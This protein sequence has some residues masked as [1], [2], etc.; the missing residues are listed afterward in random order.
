MKEMRKAFLCLTLAAVFALLAAFP[1]MFP[2]GGNTVYADGNGF[3]I[4]DGV[5]YSYTGSASK[6]VIPGSVTS[7][8]SWAFYCCSDMK[9]VTIPASVKSIGDYAFY[10][11]GG[12][13]GVTLPNSVA[14]LGDH[15]FSNCTGL[16]SVTISKSVKT[17]GEE[18]F[19]SCTSLENVTVD[20]GNT[21]FSSA[22][23]ILYNKDK[24]R[25]LFCPVA[26]SG[27]LTL[28]STLTEIGDYAFAYCDRLTG[29]TL[30][31]S[32]KKIGAWAF[33]FC[34]GLTSLTIPDSVTAI[35][36]HAFDGCGS[37]QTVT[38]SGSA[39]AIGEYAFSGCRSLKSIT[40]PATLK[41]LGEGAFWG[42]GSLTA[43]NIPKSVTGIGSMAFYGM[44]KL[45][46]ISVDSANANYSSEAGVL[47]N[48]NK[49]L[50][51]AC[52]SGKT[53]TVTLPSSVTRVEGAAFSGCGMITAINLPSSLTAIGKRA[54]ESCTGLTVMTVPDSI[55][56]IGE[57]AF[58]GC[59]ALQEVRYPGTAQ[60]WKKLLT[61]ASGVQLDAGLTS[62]V[63]MQYNYTPAPA[64]KITSQPTG[65]TV[66]KGSSFTI[67]VKA[68]GSGLKYQWYFKKKGAS[69]W[70]IWNGRTHASETVTPNDTW[71]GIQLYCLIKDDSDHS[72]K[73][74]A[75]TV[76]LSNLAITAQPQSKT[77]V[78]G[79]SVTL[80][81][82]ATG[83]GLK[84]QWYFKKK[85]A[86]AWSVWNGRTHA[87]ETVTPNDTWDGIQLY[88]LIKDSLG[89]SLKSGT[90][91]VTFGTSAI[92]VTQQPK[93]QSIVVG[94]SLTLSVK[95]TGSD[96]KYQWYFRKKGQTS[97]SVWNNRTHAS[98]TVSPNNLWDGIQLYCK[99]TDGS[100]KSVQSSTVTVSV[101]SITS[102]P[103]NVTVAA[104]SNATFA[105]KATGSGL[106]YQWQY[107]KKGASSWSDWGSRTAASTT[108]TANATWNAMQVRCKVTDG[109]GN[110]LYS[111]AATVTIK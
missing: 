13:T 10:Y 98:E 51:I 101:L 61:D 103:A 88:C 100:G 9:E 74:E 35:G 20:S 47:Y 69:A 63:K 41:T 75:A 99:I 107:K 7:I 86:S 56:K 49:T 68:T 66:I 29:V 23:G 36:A 30:P 37:L 21:V 95:A 93:N 15:V 39:A 38:M 106:Q 4:R 60:Q 12:L 26:K 5:L 14:T 105:V 19:E 31:A 3:D 11:C 45:S 54:F 44:T 102:Q 42:C 1:P 89:A 46:A 110:Y 79:S 91:S 111:S 48:K 33:E 17:I 77:I 71:D 90:I 57:N 62:N 53:G 64:I 18:I 58:E 96:L 108:A 85:G 92:T 24:T 82:K 8:E 25:L 84:Y 59:S 32:L 34:G 65:G 52:P 70:S 76:R 83:S 67:S 50:V 28:P 6:V 72:L 94:K 104:G 55:A 2:S 97:F 43:M 40:L 80:S 87:S 16:K 81:V 109:A 27:A 73:S 78:K 22:N